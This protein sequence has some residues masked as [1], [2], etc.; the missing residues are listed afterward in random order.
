MSKTA[1]KQQD[2]VKDFFSEGAYATY[3]L[4]KEGQKSGLTLVLKHQQLDDKSHVVAEVKSA[5]EMRKFTAE[6]KEKGVLP[7][8][9]QAKDVVHF[10]EQRNGIEFA[11]ETN[12]G[13]QK[14][15]YESGKVF[16][17]DHQPTTGLMGKFEYD[18][19]MPFIKKA[20]GVEYG[21]DAEKGVYE[22]TRLE[23][24]VE[25]DAE[26]HRIGEKRALENVDN[27][28]IKVEQTHKE[29]S[30][31]DLTLEDLEVQGL[32][33]TE[34][35]LKQ[36]VHNMTMEDAEKLYKNNPDLQKRIVDQSKA[37]VGNMAQ[38]QGIKIG[39]SRVVSDPEFVKAALSLQ[40]EREIL[41]EQQREAEK[42]PEPEQ[43]KDRDVSMALG[44]ID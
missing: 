29:K 28:K 44:Y 8:R 41:R 11:V 1:E 2:S 3:P 12:K 18:K 13:L 17:K 9:V 20:V 26:N 5:G 21:V 33:P 40:E 27:F 24:T 23:P 42:T 38:E 31:S 10:M 16:E 22:I 35:T 39:N 19:E 36:Q 37:L 32:A 4:D 34:G 15:N 6:Q 25:Y 43:A 14:D 30:F 7:L